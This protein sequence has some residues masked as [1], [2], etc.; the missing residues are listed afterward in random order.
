MRLPTP[1][2]PQGINHRV[3]RRVRLAVRAAVPELERQRRGAV[4]SGA[5]SVL[6]VPPQVVPAPP[7]W[8][9]RPLVL[10]QVPALVLVL[11]LALVLALVPLPVL[12]LLL[13]PVL[14]L[15]AP[16]RGSPT[17]LATLKLPHCRHLQQCGCAA[18]ARP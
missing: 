1:L 17:L 18:S 7:L 3:S 10:V 4:V 13:V 16:V 8:L 5:M 9:L 11:V 14:V 2:R 15:V 12:A 6:L